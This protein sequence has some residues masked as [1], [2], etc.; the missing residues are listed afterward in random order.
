MGS[1]YFALGDL[2]N[3]KRSYQKVLELNPQDAGVIRFMT[4]QGWR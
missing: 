1:A 2:P 4:L 3:A